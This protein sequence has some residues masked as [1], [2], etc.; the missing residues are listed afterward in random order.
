MTP[1]QLA[2]RLT[3]H[4]HDRRR[5]RSRG[6]HLRAVGG[7]VVALPALRPGFVDAPSRRAPGAAR[8]AS[9]CTGGCSAAADV[10]SAS[11]ALLVVLSC[12]GRRASRGSAA[13]AGLP[14]VVL[15]FKIA[16]LYDR[17]QLRLVPL[18][19]RRGAAAGAARPASTRWASRSC[20]RVAARRARSAAARSP[21]SGSSASSRSWAAAIARALA[22][23]R[24]LLAGRALP[25]DRRAGAAPSASARSSRSSHAHAT[26]VATLPLAGD[27]VERLGSA[28]ER[29]PAR[30][31]AAACTASSSRRRR[32]RRSGV[33]ELIRIA[34]AV[35][36]RVSVLPAHARGRRLG[37][38]VRGR[39][40][41]DDARRPAV[42]PLAL[43]AAAQA[44]RSTSSLTAVGLLAG[45]PGHRGDRARDPARLEGPG[46][47]P[48]G[49][50]RPRR[51]ALPDLQV[52]LDGGR[53]RGAEGRLR[54]L[55]EVGDGMFKITDDPRVTRV[56]ALPAPHVARRAAAALQR[57][58]R[59][60]EPRRP[61]AARRSTRTRRCSA[62]TAAGCT[63]RPA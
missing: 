14:L 45:R 33:A 57:A 21:R 40:R 18:D 56:G 34:K 25:R 15:L 29:P 31:R 2:A 50:R 8:A 7:T 42:R 62:S 26:V 1:S 11:L 30:P 16:G 44:R 63:S 13:L 51:P 54:A 39:R 4:E 61:A 58:A 55:N 59:R 20:S 53:R 41:D 46:L 19:A 9:R 24:A 27:D 38:R 37:R 47:L 52:P 6:R 5:A 10:L 32:P 36:V 43:V 17:D 48:P 28:G 60:D 23:R 35:G 12:S 3:I 49:A 22:G